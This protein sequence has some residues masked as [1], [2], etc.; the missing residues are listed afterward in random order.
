MTRRTFGRT[1]K[2]KVDLSGLKEKVTIEVL[3]KNMSCFLT[4]FQHESHRP[5][6]ILLQFFFR[7][8]MFSKGE[9]RTEKLFGFNII[10]LIILG[11]TAAKTGGSS[12]KK[13]SLRI[14]MWGTIAM[15]LSVL[16][17]Y[18]FGINI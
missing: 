9:I 7:K 15:V 5:S 12:I 6:G 4:K 13:A 3:A 18:L 10:F 8:T 2:A 1:S 17:R 11:T 14:T 16:I